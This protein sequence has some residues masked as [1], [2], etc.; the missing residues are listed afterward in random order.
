[1]SDNRTG[2]ALSGGHTSAQAADVEE[3]LLGNKAG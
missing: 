1:M 2:M 3:L